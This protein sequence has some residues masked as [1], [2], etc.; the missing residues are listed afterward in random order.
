MG[1]LNVT[2][3]SFSDGG[4]FSDADEAFARAVQMVEQGADL[5]DVGGESTRP[6]AQPVSEAEELRRVL[7]VLTR[8][9]REGI[10]VSI[11]TSKAAVA[12]Q[13]VEA[14]ASMVNDVTGGV[15]PEMRRVVANAEVDFCLMH[16]HRNPQTMQLAPM[17]GDA[18]EQVERFLS[19]QIRLCELSG[20][21]KSRLWLDPGIGFGKTT[22]QNLELLRA[23]PRF[24]QF[25][26]NVLIG[27]SRKSF[28]GKLFGTE[29][30]PLPVGE[31]GAGTAA[32]EAFALALGA[33]MIRT[34][35][36]AQAV[37]LAQ[38]SN[39]LGFSPEEH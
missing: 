14:G 9:A 20:I 12:H 23:I 3:D 30:S 8:L 39:D 4:Q 7:P 24:R 27:L 29:S 17:D 18:V 10:A 15:D 26:A 38:I 6:G 2:P 36:V 37:A 13:A 21:P 5:I 34:H 31:R 19:E 32:L 25:G 28:V 35:D 11:D 33:R 22:A 16:M 1:I